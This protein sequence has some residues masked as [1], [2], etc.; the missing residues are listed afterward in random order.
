MPIHNLLECSNNYAK[1]SAGYWQYCRDEPDAND[2]TDSE[3]FKFK[4]KLTDNTNNAGIVNV[5]TVVPLK[6]L[7]NF[8]RTFEISLIN[9]ETTL[10]LI[11]LEKYVLCKEDKVITFAITDARFHVPVITLSTQDNAK[12]LQQLKSGFKGTIQHIYQKY[13]RKPKIDI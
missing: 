9:N 10:N 7:S 5:G 11:Y 3:S 6:Y 12:L 4:S 8:W 13:Q 1:T 2:I